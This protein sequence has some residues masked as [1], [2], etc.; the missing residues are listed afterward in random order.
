LAHGL[1]PD[2]KNPNS[3]ALQ[4]WTAFIVI[5]ELK[6]TVNYEIVINLLDYLVNKASKKSWNVPFSNSF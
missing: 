3:T 6:L 5:D 4:C 2:F 1:E